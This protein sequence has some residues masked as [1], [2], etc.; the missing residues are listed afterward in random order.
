[1]DSKIELEDVATLYTKT[2]SI[3]AQ[4]E[5]LRGVI[6]CIARM[7]EVPNKE[8]ATDLRADFYDGWGE[9]L[10]RKYAQMRVPYSMIGEIREQLSSELAYIKYLLDHV[11]D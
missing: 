2:L 9:A 3:E 11:E 1:M 10:S 8:V 5:A 4:L 6:F 7:L